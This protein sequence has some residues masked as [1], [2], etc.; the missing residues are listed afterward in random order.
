MTA[1]EKE[2]L[3]QQIRN[4]VYLVSAVAV[5]FGFVIDEDMYEPVVIGLVSLINLIANGLA[6]WYSRRKFTVTAGSVEHST[7]Q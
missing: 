1:H 4:V 5:I 7:S 6:W 3:T 2:A